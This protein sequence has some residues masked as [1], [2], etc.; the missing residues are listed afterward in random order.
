MPYSE[1]CFNDISVMNDYLEVF[2]KQI[3][4]WN[5]MVILVH[6]LLM[7]FCIWEAAFNNKY[8]ETPFK[9]AKHLP[10]VLSSGISKITKLLLKLQLWYFLHLPDAS[11]HSF[12]DE[13]FS[14]KDTQLS[15]VIS[16]SQLWWYR[17]N[18]YWG[19]LTAATSNDYFI[20]SK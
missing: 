14:L 7:M 13:N 12:H 9:E 18:Q 4:I 8:N 10:Y 6:F 17:R 2:T 1:G 5:S 3:Q 20:V 19:G 16:A 11:S 15:V